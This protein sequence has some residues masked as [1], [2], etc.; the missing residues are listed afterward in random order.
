VE[1]KVLNG[2]KNFYGKDAVELL[3]LY[4]GLNSK[5]KKRAMDH[6]DELSLL[7][8][9]H[10]IPIE[11]DGYDNTDEVLHELGFS[12]TVPVVESVKNKIKA[13]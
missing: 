10:P 1:V 13:D 3:E 6:M 5:G 11:V 8:P 7:Y 4:V 9:N 2:V 12:P